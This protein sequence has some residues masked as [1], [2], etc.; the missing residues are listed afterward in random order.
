MNND[1]VK[2]FY[3]FLITDLSTEYQI[4]S[5]RR[6]SLTI[7]TYRLCRANAVT[8]SVVTDNDSIARNV[9]PGRPL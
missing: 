6:G 7:I 1:I 9:A 3:E 5:N 4:I 8:D 2:L